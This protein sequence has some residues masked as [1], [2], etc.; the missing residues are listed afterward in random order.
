MTKS[1]TTLILLLTLAFNINIEAQKQ[2]RPDSLIVIPGEEYKA[3]SFHRFFF[4]DHWRDLWTTPIKVEVLDMNSFAGGLKPI[5][6]GGGMATKSLRF[7]GKDGQF[8]KF[9]SVNKDPRKALPEELQETLVGDVLMDQTS[10]SNPFAP[11]IVNPILNAVGIL[12]AEAKLVWMPNDELLGEYRKE[13]GNVLGT[14][15]IHPDEGDEVTQAFNGAD[16][17]SGTFKLLHRLEDKRSEKVD[18]KEFLK[19]RL[20]DLFL[21]D[22]DRHTDQ[23]RWALYNRNG[24][25]LWKPIPR[26]RDQAFARFDGA[27]TRIAE[28]KVPQINHFDADY[29]QIEDLSWSG[30]FLDRMFLTEI[31]KEDWDSITVSLQSQITDSVIFNAVKMLPPEGF[32]TSGEC[33]IKDLISRREKLSGYSNE[34][35]ELTNMYIDVFASEKDDFVE[36]DRIS[37]DYT[38]IKRY[39]RSKKLGEKKEK[40]LYHKVVDNSL[41]KQ[42]RIHLLE[43]DDKVVITGVVDESP[44]VKIIGGKGKDE[45]LDNSVVNGYWM[46]FTPIP[47]EE[48]KT[49]VYDSGKKTKITYKGNLTHYDEKV[50]IPKTDE[51]LYEPEQR[52]RNTDWLPS[53]VLSIT[54]SYGLLIGGGLQ[55]YGY[56]FRVAPYDYWLNFTGAYATLPN[57][58]AIEF[59]GRFNSIIKNATVALNVSRSRLRFLNY[60]GYGNETKY[61]RELEEDDL[62][63][64]E[65]ESFQA[66]LLVEKEI[67]NKTKISVGVLY[68]DSE[69]ELDYPQ[70]INSFPIKDYGRGTLNDIGFNAAILY[71]SRDNSVLTTKG[72]YIEAD[73]KYYPEIFDNMIQF[74][75]AG[76][77]V[78]SYFSSSNSKV[79]FAGRISGRKIWGDFPIHRAVFLGGNND[80][81]GLSLRR[82]SGSAMLFGQSELRTDLTKLKIIIPADLGVF[83]FAETGR[84]F[85]KNDK[86]EVWHSSFGGGMYLAFLNRSLLA[87]FSLGFSDERTTFY[88]N[89]SMAY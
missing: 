52:D 26:D 48:T 24:E 62:Y 27:L 46:N 50:K 84:V 15:E 88:L 39:S 12:H 78:R 1:F 89:F 43:G 25:K 47:S 29:P 34:Y 80:L 69:I 54:S 31:T 53:S 21:G 61:N 67:F 40:I 8:W 36:V 58:Y 70:L 63:R 64:L 60:Y 30:R 3:G 49:E 5:K 4:G 55:Q 44:L 82:F 51:E 16:K 20:T 14:I 6:R 18:S 11:L 68:E 7:K 33:L 85:I 79:T 45:I 83:G 59:N 81:R 56:D 22:W 66:E 19:A 71:D 42:I 9:R 37:D 35:Y 73:G 77:D 75:N 87:T 13:F 57:T 28:Y 72:I 17:V 2:L 32:K 86:S 23:W 41:T 74:L 76:F 10:S 38:V 65:Q